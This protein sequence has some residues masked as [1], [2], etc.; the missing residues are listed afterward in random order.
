MR[1]KA[2]S[3]TL[4][5]AIEARL[6]ES[7]YGRQ[8]AI[9]ED[10]HLLIVLHTPPEPDTHAR[11]PEVFLRKPDGSWWHNGMTNGELKLQKLLASYRELLQQYEGAYERA[12]S[13]TDLF[14]ILDDLASLNR[15]AANL[16]SALQAARELMKAD[17]LLIAVRDEAYEVSRSFELLFHE[18]KLALDYRIARSAEAQMAKAAEMAA[19]QHKLNVLAAV[20]FPLMAIATIFGMNL[21]HGLENQPPAVFWT[22][23]L[24]GAGVGA[25]AVYWV[26]SHAKGGRTAGR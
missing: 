21:V 3:W 1:R 17:K 14:A 8:R 18:A 22:V 13:A 11:H 25:L 4:P 9:L 15:A 2:F 7:T 24:V 20:T 16:G 6:G 10:D 12:D 19:A 5:Q 23:L 26:T